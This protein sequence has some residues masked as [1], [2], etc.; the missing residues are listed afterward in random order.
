MDL[1]WYKKPKNFWLLVLFCASISFW[2]FICL[3]VIHKFRNS[4]DG[5]IIEAVEWIASL[6]ILSLPFTLEG[7]Y[8]NDKKGKPIEFKMYLALIL[9]GAIYAGIFA[10]PL[11]ILFWLLNIKSFLGI[12]CNLP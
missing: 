8:N 2:G 12:P 5:I 3:A 4:N 9:I 7:I 1:K 6:L 11:Y 10:M